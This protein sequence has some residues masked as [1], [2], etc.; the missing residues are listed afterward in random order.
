MG[1]KVLGVSLGRFVESESA[2]ELPGK[3]MIEATVTAAHASNRRK[4]VN[5]V[6]WVQVVFSLCLSFVINLESNA[7]GEKQASRFKRGNRVW[8]L[9]THHGSHP[10]LM[11]HVPADGFTD[12]LLEF[13]SGE[14]AEILLDFCSIDRVA[15]IMTRPVFNEG[16]KLAR[17]AA[18]LGSELI[19]QI[20]DQLDNMD[21]GPFIVTA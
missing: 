20:A 18:E 21:V 16:D 1:L 7:W 12:A 5:L 15:A 17:V 10:L 6:L 4:I 11:F 13:M 3:S 2:C 19:N 14:P 8:K 9:F